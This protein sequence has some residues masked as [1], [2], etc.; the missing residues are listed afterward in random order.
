MPG[1]GRRMRAA[2]LQ[3]MPGP[4]FYAG[5]SVGDPGDAAATLN[6]PTIGAFGYARKPFFWNPTVNTPVSGSPALLVSFDQL[7]W[8]ATGPWAASMTQPVTHIAVWTAA[9][10]IAE[11]GYVGAALLSPPRLMDRAGIVITILAGTLQLTIG[12]ED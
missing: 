1:F 9:T 7:T 11:S 3:T 5:L 10:G 4:L 12:L 2:L 6:E 8:T